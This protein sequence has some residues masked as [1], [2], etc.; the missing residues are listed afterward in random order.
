[1]PV[2]FRNIRCSTKH[3]PGNP[4][5]VPF[6]YPRVLPGA[7]SQGRQQDQRQRPADDA[8]GGAQAAAQPAAQHSEE[9]RHQAHQA[10]D[11]CRRRPEPPVVGQGG[12]GQ[13][14]GSLTGQIHA[15]VGRR[16]TQHSQCLTGIPFPP[17]R[18]P[19][20]PVHG[21]GPLLGR[22]AVPVEDQE[23]HQDQRI[24][25]G[26]DHGRPEFPCLPGYECVDQHIRRGNFSGFPENEQHILKKGDPHRQKQGPQPSAVHPCTARN[27]FRIPSVVHPM[28]TAANIP[29]TAATYTPLRDPIPKGAR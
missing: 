13:G 17:V 6:Q 18:H 25:H 10:P 1:M 7:R 23:Q 20:K 11:P 14:H 3:S 28:V 5:R 22:H 16:P 15:A 2:F 24:F 8:H 29:H 9:P 19:G 26:Q 27:P 21:S 4:A 12:P